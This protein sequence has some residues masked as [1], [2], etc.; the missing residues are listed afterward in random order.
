MRRSSTKNVIKTAW[1]TLAIIA[2]ALGGIWVARLVSHSKASSDAQN[3]SYIV[4]GALVKLVDGVA[5]TE[6]APKSASKTTIRYFG[7]EAKGDVNRDGKSDIAFILTSDNGGSG[8]FYYVAVALASESG[9]RGT[10]ALFLGDR[11]APQ[12]TEIR[13]GDIVVNYAERGSDE[14]MTAKPSIGVSKSF[15]VSDGKLVLQNP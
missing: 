5:T 7:N 3:A 11:I 4:E 13:G 2:L 9:Y 10:N 14:P 8:T 6:T 12:T 15:K 1:I